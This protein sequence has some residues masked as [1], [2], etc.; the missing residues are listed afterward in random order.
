MFCVWCVEFFVVWFGVSIIE[1]T[2]RETE[3]AVHD[4][5]LL[6]ILATILFY[7]GAETLVMDDVECVGCGK[8]GTRSKGAFGSGSAG[9][10][11]V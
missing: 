9:K 6:I 1:E 7:A 11:S 10:R 5:L 4:L 2:C 3:D 8:D